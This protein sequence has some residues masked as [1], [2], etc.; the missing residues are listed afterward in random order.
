MEYAAHGGEALARIEQAEPDLV[1]TDLIMP[2]VN[3]L[4]LVTA[5]RERHPLVPVVLMTSKG[6]E[7]L[8]VEALALGAAGYVP[9]RTLAWKLPEAV[10]K[11][12]AVSGRQRSHTRLMGC[13]TQSNSAFVL[14]NDCALIPPLVTYLQES[15][16]Q[17]GLCARG[18]PHAHRH[19]PGGGPGQRPL[20]RQPRDRLRSPR[21]DERAYRALVQ[22][23]RRAPPYRDRRIHVEAT[24]GGA[25]A[26]FEIRD[27]GPG[28]DPSGLPDPTDPANLEK[29]SGRGILLMQTFMDA[30]RF[31]DRGNAV[32]LVKRC[33]RPSR[34]SLHSFRRVGQASGIPGGPAV[35]R[36]DSTLGGV[37]ERTPGAGCAG[38]PET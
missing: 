2:E 25:G 38:P 14:E 27:E 16:A 28:F 5:I 26:A 34:R 35:A 6:C 22:Q 21:H 8:A 32:T 23:R 7:E 19:R 15:V 13:M 31:N 11:V 33:K 10:C 37:L 1:L 24:L 29:C 12:L 3:G 20:P 9:K 18:R 4:E 30:V 17:L 36:A